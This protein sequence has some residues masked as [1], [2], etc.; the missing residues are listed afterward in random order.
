MNGVDIAVVLVLGL[1]AFRGY[2]NGFVHEVLSLLAL[3]AAFLAAF[4]WTGALTP[5]IADSVPG[6]AFIDTGVAFLI[7]FGLTLTTGRYVV[8]TVRR[9]WLQPRTSTANRLA[10]AMFGTFKGAVVMGF[11]LLMLRGA[12][13]EAYASEAIPDGAA[14]KVV[15]INAQAEQSYLGARLVDLT[16]GTFSALMASAEGQVR[17]LASGGGVAEGS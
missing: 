13:P 12:A 16:N 10:G 3:C 5:R 6:P 15:A 7:L 14:G 4:R 11:V 9:M 1:F 8:T 2:A 17:S